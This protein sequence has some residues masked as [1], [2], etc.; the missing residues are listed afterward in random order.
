MERLFLKKLEKFK[1]TKRLYTISHL[2][3]IRQLIEILNYQL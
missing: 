3:P 2:Y 1:I